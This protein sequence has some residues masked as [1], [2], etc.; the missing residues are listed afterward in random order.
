M[1]GVKLFAEQA[2]SLREG[3]LVKL[4]PYTFV[5]S[6]DS[7]R[8]LGSTVSADIDAGR[9]LVRTI[10][11]GMSMVDG[12]SRV[13]SGIVDPML[14]LLLASA[15]L[16]HASTDETMLAERLIDAALRGSGMHNA[17]VVRPADGKGSYDVVASRFAGDQPLSFSRSLLDAASNGEATELAAANAGGGPIGDVSQ[18]IVQ[19]SIV[20]AICVPLVIGN[21]DPAAGEA[22]VAMYLYLDSRGSTVRQVRPQARE[23]CVALGRIA[24]LSLANLK[25]LD[26]E[27]RQASL[28]SELKNAAKMQAWML[29]QRNTT[30]GPLACIGESRFGQA[31]GGDFFDLIDLGDGK[32]AVT[33]GDVSGKGITASVMMTA[34]QG[35]LHASLRDTRDPLRA[36]RAAHA[37]LMPRKPIGKFVTA[38]VGVID[39]NDRT[40]RYVD[41]GHGYA[42][43]QGSQGDCQTLTG[44]GG[45]PIGM[46][47][48]CEYEAAEIDIAPGARLLL[49][50]DGII[51]QFGMVVA[52][53]G[54]STR[55]QFG[56]DGAIRCLMTT[57]GTAD[58]V[59]CLFESL[60]RHAATTSLSDDATAVLVSG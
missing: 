24:S 18:S 9:T 21:T 6:T 23:F 44:G 41:A 29:P 27:R 38:W 13:G 58:P 4:S 46:V 40:L 35:Y 15:D 56:I 1:N 8:R 20:N 60:I 50:S 53:D 19:M 7:A 47:E 39:L 54:T 30:L 45:P 32:L 36:V 3:D 43:L 16:V 31:L 49:M 28:E 12:T 34:T 22:T 2:V 48:E 37:F 42:V 52:A 26:I 11:G 33:I 57:R 10:G 59:R 5:F 55:E 14:E 51:E 25:R 17:A